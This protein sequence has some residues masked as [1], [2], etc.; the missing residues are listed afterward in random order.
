MNRF[1]LHVYESS[2]DQNRQLMFFIVKEM[3]KAVET[4]HHSFGG[5]E[6]MQHFPVGCRQSNSASGEI[7]PV[8]CSL[9]ARRATGLRESLESGATKEESLL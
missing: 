1:E 5:G 4:F 2:L 8:F 9:R 6:Q 7:H 3:F